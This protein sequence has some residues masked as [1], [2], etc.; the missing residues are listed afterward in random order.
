VR[1]WPTGQP[2]SA[3]SSTYTPLWV[4]IRAAMPAGGRHWHPLPLRRRC[5]GRLGAMHQILGSVAP[6]L[7]AV[8]VATTYSRPKDQVLVARLSAK[9]PSPLRRKKRRS[10]LA[11]AAEQHKVA[12]APLTR[13]GSVAVRHSPGRVRVFARR[14]GGVSARGPLR[15]RAILR[16]P[17]VDLDG[18]LDPD[19]PRVGAVRRIGF[20][21]A[22]TFEGGVPA[23]EHA[24][25]VAAERQL[26]VDRPSR[27][28]PVA[29]HSCRHAISLPGR[30][31]LPPRR[32]RG[33]PE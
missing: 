5:Q 17:V 3:C 19:V 20:L 28:R 33:S 23:V 31:T 6:D 9:R 27:S 24:Q 8:P 13:S 2:Q 32:E 29:T 25:A 12:A 26:A 10:A 15:I 11:E 1:T 21:L 30:R 16:G 22:R 7:R 4:G 14:S 18:T